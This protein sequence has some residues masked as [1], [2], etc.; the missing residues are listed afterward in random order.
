MNQKNINRRAFLRNSALAAAAV[1][2]TPGSAFPVNTPAVK[3][4]LPRWKGFNL[5]DLFSPLLRGI[6]IQPGPPKRILNG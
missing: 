2:L 3:N 4:K 5:L 1:T 6:K